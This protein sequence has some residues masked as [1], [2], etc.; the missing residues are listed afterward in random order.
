[1]ATS[2]FPQ[3]VQRSKNLVEFKAGKCLREGDTNVVKADTRKGL[4]YL[5]QGEDS[6]MH[7][8]WKDRKT[9]SVEDD[10][11]IFPDEAEFLKVEESDG[12]VYVLKFKSSSLRMF[13][14]MQDKS[15]E[16]DEELRSRVNEVLNNPSALYG[17]S[18][19][20]AF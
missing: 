10:L 9:N 13:F 4:V 8:Y 6:L 7:F 3:P 15:S 12:R 20:M 5:K 14:W 11:I 2:L 17:G 18:E 16:Q 19:E 1:M